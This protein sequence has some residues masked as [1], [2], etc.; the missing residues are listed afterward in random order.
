MQLVAKDL[1]ITERFKLFSNGQEVLDFLHCF[2]YEQTSVRPKNS[3]Q[4][5]QPI[6][7]ILLDI[8]MPILDGL[9]TL[10]MVKQLFE[11]YEDKQIQRPM[12]SYLSQNDYSVM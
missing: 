3:A 2:F 1:G 7:L 4:F 5:I 8:N 6:K 12:I 9:E 10:K 11:K